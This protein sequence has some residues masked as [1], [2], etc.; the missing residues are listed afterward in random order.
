MVDQTD[1]Y[2][3]WIGRRETLVDF[4]DPRSIANMDVLLG[5]DGAWPRKGDPIANFWHCM[6]FA[7]RAP[8]DDLGP[9]GHPRRGD[10]MPPIPLPRRMYAG[11][12]MDFIAPLHVGDHVECHTVIAD[13]TSK[14]GRS[15][16]LVFVV[17]ADEIRSDGVTKIMQ[18]RTLVFTEAVNKDFSDTSSP[19]PAPDE[20][21]WRQEITPDPITLFRFS[22]LTFNGHRIH[23]D[24][25][26]ATGVEGYPDLVVHGPFIALWLITACQRANANRPIKSFSYRT[27]APLFADASFSVAGKLDRS[28]AAATLWAAGRDK[29]LA[30]TGKVVFAD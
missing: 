15:G 3:K 26:Y 22:A 17:L 2:R 19:K 24:H 11:A 20:A 8:H 1:T 9:D 14:H 16:A 4:V 21:D 10:F 6:N 7:P 13:I 5:G 27:H 29:C 30:M 18:K 25:P 28:R 12:E 23:Y